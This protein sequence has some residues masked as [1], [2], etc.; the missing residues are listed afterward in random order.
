QWMWR[1]VTLVPDRAPT[2]NLQ[3]WYERLQQRKAFAKIV[4]QPLV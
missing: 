3:A 4:M 2:P 1:Y